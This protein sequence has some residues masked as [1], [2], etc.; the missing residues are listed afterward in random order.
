MIKKVNTEI[1]QHEAKS[2]NEY[3]KQRIDEI[4]NDRNSAT[5]SKF[6]KKTDP[7]SVI[8]NQQLFAVTYQNV[9]NKAQKITSAVPSVVKTTVAAV[10]GKIFETAT[11]NPNQDM[12]FTQTKTFSDIRKRIINTKSKTIVT[13]FSEQEIR[14]AIMKQAN[15][16]Q[17][18]P[19]RV[20]NEV[21][22]YLADNEKFIK[23]YTK[24]FNSVLVH[25]LHFLATFEIFF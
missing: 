23:I 13:P 22:K 9:K 21:F 17:S 14:K 19:D 3:I 25:S 18:G 15:N 8:P 16:K 11:K 2:K 6:F 5:P 1:S 10:W 20:P 12:P 7:E 4:R 24:I